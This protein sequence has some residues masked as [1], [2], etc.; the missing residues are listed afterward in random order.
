MELEVVK[1]QAFL[2]QLVI[3]EPEGVLRP[4]EK[5]AFM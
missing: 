5:D 3:F 1:A 2:P 4:L